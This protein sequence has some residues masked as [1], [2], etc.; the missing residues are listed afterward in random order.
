MGISKARILL[1]AIF[2]LLPSTI[3]IPCYK[4]F[5]RY[6]IGSGVKIGC[7]V[8]SAGSCEIGDG[9][10]IG[11]L[12]LLVGTKRI[13]IGEKTN[14]GHLN[15]IRG[16]DQVSIGRYAEI[17]RLNEINAIPDPIA[18]NPVDS[19]FLL[20]DG[21]IITTSHKIDFTDRVEIGKRSILGGRNSSL[22]THNRQATKPIVIG[23]Y[24]YIG[25][26]IRIAPGGVIPASCIVGIGSVITKKLETE[27]SLVGGVPAKTIK[28]LDD[29]GRKLTRFKTRLDLPDEIQ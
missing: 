9:V 17:L 20:G 6:K 21:S 5:W 7:S 11:H 2:S 4:A 15:I 24:C 12:N 25:S 1:H 29:E 22:W 14:I 23:D 26:E 8:I 13:T 19:R 3:K 28:P 18:S 16:G 10:S 27:Y